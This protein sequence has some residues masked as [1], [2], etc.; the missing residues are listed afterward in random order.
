MKAFDFSVLLIRAKPDQFQEGSLIKVKVDLKPHPDKLTSRFAAQYTSTKHTFELKSWN[1]TY[2]LES[3]LSVTFLR[4]GSG[5]SQLRSGILLIAWHIQTFTPQTL[6]NLLPEVDS[7]FFSALHHWMI[8]PT[9][10]HIPTCH[11]WDNKRKWES[12]WQMAPSTP[13]NKDSHFIR[14]RRHSSLTDLLW[15]GA[16]HRCS[17]SQ[18]R[19]KEKVI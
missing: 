5:R 16:R 10:T 17:S 3:T 8:S 18:K 15:Q 14:R 2:S 4:F 13:N 9:Q 1:S 7:S 6:I 19:R 11:L 12:Q